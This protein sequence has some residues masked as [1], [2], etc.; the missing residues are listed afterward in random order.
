MNL[1]DTSK[2]SRNGPESKIDLKFLCYSKKEY[3]ML[4][5]YKY[6]ITDC[7]FMENG[8]VFISENDL[9]MKH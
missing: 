1:G 8:D 5:Y 2:N 3:I 4:T 9:Y 7:K 6:I